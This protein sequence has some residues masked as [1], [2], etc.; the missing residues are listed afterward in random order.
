M[1]KVRTLWLLHLWLF[2]ASTVCAVERGIVVTSQ[3]SVITNFEAPG[4]VSGAFLIS[5]LDSIPHELTEGVAVPSGWQ[6]ISGRGTFV[7]RPGAQEVRLIAAVI[8]GRTPPG[9]YH[10]TYTAHDQNE[11][12]STNQQVLSTHATPNISVRLIVL[13]AP[14][15][16][17]ASAPN[18]D[19]FTCD[20]TRTEIAN[21]E[22]IVKTSA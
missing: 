9:E 5:N 19:T 2:C 20:H 8:K 17:V 10:I 1:Y 22:L 11:P 7:L 3:D 15:Y 21:D 16:V 13:L 4:I 6:L 18:K 12:T 14:L